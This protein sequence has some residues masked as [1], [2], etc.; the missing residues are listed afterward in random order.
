MPFLPIQKNALL[1][2]IKR[3][4]VGNLSRSEY[5]ADDIST[6]MDPS[7]SYTIALRK[8]IAAKGGKWYAGIGVQYVQLKENIRLAG[9][10][11]NTQYN[12]IKRLDNT[13]SFLVDDTVATVTK[14]TRIINAVNSFQLISLPV[15]AQ[16]QILQNKAWQ[17]SVNGGLNFTV[18]KMYQNSIA[19]TLVT[20]YT[21]A[22]LAN[23]KEHAISTDILQV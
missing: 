14:G 13:G 19:G 15:F 20:D 2:N 3:T 10:E 1:V 7:F 17:L 5:T 22:A 11:I 12:V 23:K 9:K 16:Y 8:K 4:T 6:N 18:K 21:S